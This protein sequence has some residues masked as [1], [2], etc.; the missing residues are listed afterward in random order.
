MALSELGLIPK[1][2]RLHPNFK[3]VLHASFRNKEESIALDMLENLQKLMTKRGKDNFQFKL[4][5]TAGK[6]WDQEFLKKELG[7]YKEVK[8]IWA[9]G[10][11]IME[12]KF[13]KCLEAIATDLGIIFKTQVDIM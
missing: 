4:K 3:L 10:P 6:R 7:S 12:E 1:S 2:E 8:K 11:P 13:D 9:C 5:P